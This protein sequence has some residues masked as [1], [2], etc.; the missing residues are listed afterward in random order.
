MGR[1]HK[2]KKSLNILG[3]N[4]DNN[5]ILKD[6]FSNNLNKEEKYEENAMIGL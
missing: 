3:K 6:L 4:F 2:F 1:E 5:I